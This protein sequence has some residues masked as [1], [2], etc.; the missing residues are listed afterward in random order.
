MHMNHRP[1]VLAASSCALLG[2]VAAAQ[3][4]RLLR[5]PTVSRDQVA[6]AY[7][8]DV[9]V[10][11]RS[12]GTARRITSTLSVEAEPRFSPDGTQIAYSATVGGNMD[13]YVVPA[14]G[15]EPRRLTYHPGNDA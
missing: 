11:P 15:G 1:F 5:S 10:V 9:W 3:G 8:S 2:T 7:A 14:A 13:V 12:G 4:T 6:F